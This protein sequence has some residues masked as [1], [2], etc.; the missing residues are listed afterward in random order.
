[1]VKLDIRHRIDCRLADFRTVDLVPQVV[2]EPVVHKAVVQDVRA[3]RFHLARTKQA[4]E[5][6]KRIGIFLFRLEINGK[7]NDV[8][9]AFL[10]QPYCRLAGARQ[11]PVVGIG[12]HDVIP[13]GVQK[14]QLAGKDRSQTALKCRGMEARFAV[15]IVPENVGGSI[16]RRII[17]ADDL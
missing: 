16:G 12:E 3:V 6:V 10:H 2:H 4:D 15:K 11:K 14:S 8:G 1:M 7:L 17:D 13:L 5:P 9:F